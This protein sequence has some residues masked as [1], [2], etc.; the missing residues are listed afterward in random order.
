MKH[1]DI[2]TA[3]PLVPETSAFE[4]DLAIEKVRGHKSPGIDQIPAELITAGIRKIRYEF[5][6]I[7]ISVWNKEELT[8]EWKESIIVPFYKK[9]LKQIV[10]IIRAYH[11]CQLHKKFYAAAFFYKITPICRGN[12]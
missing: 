3:E 4:T 10:V 5:H 2:H 6:K 9:G 11:F 12:D 7:I 1:T 8:E